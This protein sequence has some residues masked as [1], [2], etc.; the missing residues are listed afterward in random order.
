MS[1]DCYSDGY[2]EC[3][4]R[5]LSTKIDGVSKMKGMLIWSIFYREQVC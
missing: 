1:S 4:M 5:I 3:K 2:N